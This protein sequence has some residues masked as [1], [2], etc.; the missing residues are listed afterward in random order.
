M[1]KLVIAAIAA[2]A[3]VLPAQA[4]KSQSSATS[5]FVQKVAISDMFEIQSSRLAQQK[6]NNDGVKTFAQHMVTDH[7]KTT[8]ELK[9]IAQKI[10]GVQIP[11]QLDATHQK[12]LDKLN[13]LSGAKFDV[14]YKADQVQG[15]VQAVRLFAAYAKNGD[16]A[17]LKKWAHDT[18]PTLREHLRMAR[19][20]PRD[21]HVS[22]R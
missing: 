16:N 13:G 9:P 18:L 20:V 22:S 21:Q 3:L 6:S 14:A 1:Q 8:D 19:A 12:M 4:Q 15:H 7:T 5:D 17:D 11:V 10:Q 2:V